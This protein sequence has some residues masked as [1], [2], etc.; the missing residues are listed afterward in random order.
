MPAGNIWQDYQ[1]KPP[2]ETILLNQGELE[3]VR[4]LNETQRKERCKKCDCLGHIDCP[5]CKRHGHLKCTECEQTGKIECCTTETCRNCAGRGSFVCEKCAG[6]GRYDCPEC[7]SHG[8]VRCPQCKGHKF[9]VVW[10]RLHV[11][12]YNVN[13][14]IAHQ[15]D[16]GCILP[17]SEIKNASGKVTCL[18]YD[19][20]WSPSVNSIADVFNTC[21]DLPDVFRNKV[22]TEYR[23]EHCTKRGKM[24]RLQCDVKR[25]KIKEFEYQ[26]NN[27]PSKRIFMEI[28]C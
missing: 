21:V 24:L 17:S 4:D 15:P 9:V 11:K 8:Q 19:S 22:Y 1:F 13:S 12:W 7:C 2:G 27:I 5:K 23:I 28:I 16:A 6:H 14:I 26:L 3:S 25:L 20:P 10:T 18:V